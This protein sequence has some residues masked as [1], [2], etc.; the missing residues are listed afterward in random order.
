VEEGELRLWLRKNAVAWRRVDGE[1]I[2]LDTAASTYLGVNR[3]GSA[4][5]PALVEGTTRGQLIKRLCERFEVTENEASDD[6][7]TFLGTCRERGLLGS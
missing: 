5:W 6:V 3:T 2:L 4:L 7:D 1:T